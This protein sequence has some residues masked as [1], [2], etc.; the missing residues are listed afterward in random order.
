MSTSGRGEAEPSM[1]EHQTALTEVSF[2]LEMLSSTIK[3]VVGGGTATVCRNAGRHMGKKLPVYLKEPTLEQAA[4]TVCDHLKGGFEIRVQIPEPDV[5][6]M[7]FGRCP[8]RAVCGSR[9]QDL[10]GDLCSM[11]H[12]YLGGILNELTGRPCR[13]AIQSTGA[14]ECSIRVDAT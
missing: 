12:W 1:K 5:A 9:S 13:S 14:S 10:G 11:F 8:I 6:D 2:L 4:T 7:T 3:E